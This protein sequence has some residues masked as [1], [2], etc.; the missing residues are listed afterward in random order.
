MSNKVPSSFL[1]QQPPPQHH[2]MR[3]S[4]TTTNVTLRSTSA[5]R[6]STYNRHSS[7]GGGCNTTME[8]DV[9]EDSDFTNN[10][11]DNNGG[12]VAVGQS[13]RVGFHG[14]PLGKPL[15]RNNSSD[16]IQHNIG[17]RLAS[18]D[19]PY[20]F[21]NPM[22]S[23]HQH[24]HHNHGYQHHSGHQH[25]STSNPRLSGVNGFSP[26]PRNHQHQHHLPQHPSTS[27]Y[28]HNHPRGDSSSPPHSPIAHR[29]QRFGF[30]TTTL[31]RK[32]LNNQQYLPNG[33]LPQHSGSSTLGRN[34]RGQSGGQQSSGFSGFGLKK[35]KSADRLINWSSRSDSP[36]LPPP[37][38]PPLMASMRHLNYDTK[39]SL[40]V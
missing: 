17:S 36:P 9:F 39:P 7:I 30:A 37:P 1:Q 31:P 23:Q 24:Q 29:H 16:L 19:Q 3:P 4:T 8:D 40:I 25:H 10:S 2:L 11:G 13:N 6:R 35:L 22:A 32:Q 15:V 38:P 12:V 20:S 27:S 33:N 26:P 34:K 28:Y 18:M 14:H 5:N 21:T